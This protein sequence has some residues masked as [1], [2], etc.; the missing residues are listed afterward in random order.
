MLEVIYQ[1]GARDCLV[2]MS[3]DIM[4]DNMSLVW[5][6]SS[7]YLTDVLALLD[8]ETR[9]FSIFALILGALTAVFSFHCSC[10]VPS[11]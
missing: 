2:A 7:H 9:M 10:I 1:K 3:S 5:F 6:L 4:Y 8:A 11:G